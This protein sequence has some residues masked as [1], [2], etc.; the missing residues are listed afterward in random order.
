[1]YRK[2]RNA[3]FLFSHFYV[4]NKSV[5]KI[6][7]FIHLPFMLVISVRILENNGKGKPRKVYQ[8]NI[9][10]KVVLEDAWCKTIK[11]IETCN[12]RTLSECGKSEKFQSKDKKLNIWGRSDKYLAYKRKTKILEKWR[13]ISQHSLL[14]AR[15]TWSD[16]APTSWTRLR[17]TFSV[18]LQS[19]PPWR[20]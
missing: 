20:R 15:Y 13:F 12:V 6:F 11:R 14:L 1:M 18:D 5:R 4:E 17:N 8:S 7:K 9:W 10:T 16:D 3:Q 19:R 2:Q